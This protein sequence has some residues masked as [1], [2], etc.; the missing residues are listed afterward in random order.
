MFITLRK[1]LIISA[2]LLLSACTNKYTTIRHSTSFDQERIK[3]SPIV[4]LPTEAI[5]NEV[6]FAGKKKRVEDFEF[7]MEDIVNSSLVKKLKEEGFRNVTHYT[8]KDIYLQKTSRQI[9][10][11]REK[12]NMALDVLYKSPTMKK[13]Q[14]FAIDHNL[15][16]IEFSFDAPKPLILFS[17]Y[18]AD[19]KTNGARTKDF[20][21]AALVGARAVDPGEVGKLIL[22]FVELESGEFLWGN[23]SLYADSSLGDFFKKDA[24]YYEAQDR[25]KVEKIIQDSLLPLR[26]GQKK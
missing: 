3:N 15:G 24:A 12:Y 1:Y 21:I 13:E 20:L 10:N 11:L 23:L 7:Y 25:K 14:A 19:V 17:H 9:L 2:I 26:E 8:K 5:V 22:G 16:K 4:V 18:V 6:D